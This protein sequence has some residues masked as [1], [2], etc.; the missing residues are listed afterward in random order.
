MSDK[1]KI[2]A[3]NV[4]LSKVDCEE[5]KASLNRIS[6]RIN[7]VQVKVVTARDDEQIKS[8][9]KINVIIR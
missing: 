5:V 4:S 3:D 1:P 9:E 7:A 2:E 6:K 8:L